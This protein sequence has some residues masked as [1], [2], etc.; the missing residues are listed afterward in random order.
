MVFFR[1]TTLR[2]IPQHHYPD[3]LGYFDKAVFSE[4]KKPKYWEQAYHR[5]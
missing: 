3:F 5:E 1:D 2:K 4:N